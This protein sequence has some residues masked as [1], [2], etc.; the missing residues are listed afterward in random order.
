MLRNMAKYKII[1]DKEACLGCHS[2]VSICPHNWEENG[3]KVKPKK[4]EIGDNELKINKEAEEVCPIGAIK[5]KEI[6]K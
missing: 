1:Y 5:I 2:C 3:D 4:T 6:K